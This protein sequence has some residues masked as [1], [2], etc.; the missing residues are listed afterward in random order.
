MPTRFSKRGIPG[1]EGGTAIAE[2]L[3]GIN[4]PGGRLPVTFMLRWTRF[5]PF[6]DYSMQGR[7]Y[8]YFDGKPLYGFGYGLSYTTFAYS[9]LKLSSD[10][11]KAGDTLKVEVDVRNAGK[12]A[13]DEVAELYLSKDADAPAHLI[14]TLRGFERLHLAA[15]QSKHVTF[16]LASSRPEP[17]DG[18]RRTCGAARRL[19]DFRGEQ[20]TKRRSE[21]RL[22]GF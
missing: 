21:R 10:K 4:N 12:V 16:T 22:G 11:P 19:Q 15:G 17:G 3:A 8:R 14:R 9:G 2:T 6:D 5:L 20:S 7:T 18:P 13:G 1:E